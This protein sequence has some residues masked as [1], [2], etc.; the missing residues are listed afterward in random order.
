MCKSSK[1]Y[2][3]GEAQGRTVQTQITCAEETCGLHVSV[4][5]HFTIRKLSTCLV[6]TQNSHTLQHPESKPYLG[7]G[8]TGLPLNIVAFIPRICV[9]PTA[10]TVP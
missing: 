8:G 2:L 4:L 3:N 9:L 5:W 6:W 1:G 7:F 10:E